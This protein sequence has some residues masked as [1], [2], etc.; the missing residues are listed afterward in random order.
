[1]KHADVELETGQA[2]VIYD[3]TQQT[4]EKLPSAIDMLGF[5]AS[6]VSVVAAPTGEAPARRT[7][8]SFSIGDPLKGE[9]EARRSEPVPRSPN[10]E[11]RDVNPPSGTSSSLSSDASVRFDAS[12][13]ASTLDGPRRRVAPGGRRSSRMLGP[14]G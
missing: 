7:A 4:P 9:T 14:A 3:H 10:H 6:I 8:S 2:R 1:M 12:R 13:S 5:K 11:A